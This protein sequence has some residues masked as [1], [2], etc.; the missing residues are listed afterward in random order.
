MRFLIQATI[1]IDMLN[2]MVQDPDTF[3]EKAENYFKTLK[4]EATY[5]IEVNGERT[6]VLVIDIQTAEMIDVVVDSLALEFG[7]KVQIRPALI[8]ED[9]KKSIQLRKDLK[10]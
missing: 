3:L 6:V 8:L 10:R 5:F 9:L 1:P 2:K 7:A 4:P